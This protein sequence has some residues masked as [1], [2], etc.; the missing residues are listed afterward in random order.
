MRRGALCALG[1]LILVAFVASPSAQGVVQEQ[2]PTFRAAVDLVSVAA[3]VRDRHGRFVHD[4]Q[5][6]DFSV[7]EAGHVRPI[8]EFHA[9]DDAPVR[10]ALLF[11]V[12]G[13]MQVASKIEAARQAARQVLSS[14]RLAGRA[15]HDEAA[16]FSFDTRLQSLQGFTTDPTAIEDALARVAPFGETSL[17]D[18][19]AQT[20][21]RV[22]ASA[23]AGAQRRAVIVLT[24]GVDTSSRLTPAQVSGIA[25]E[26]DVPVYVMAVVSP[27]DHPGDPESVVP[28][29]GDDPGALQ[30]LAYWTGGE[31][32]MT[33]A[34]AHA[35]LAARQI[36]DELRHQYVFAFDATPGS[37]WRRLEV[38]TKD[39]NLT[40]RA[41]SGYIAGS[42][43]APLQP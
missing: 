27:L 32:F 8:V 15:S 9:D 25:S 22:A 4:L 34:P 24:D 26:I 6:K 33:S 17:Y 18:A 40:V 20:A 36:I 14:L 37:G 29:R 10:I 23:D 7:L 5:Q 39:R 41:R 28:A 3:V 16:V 43:G 35:S 11:D 13:S 2:R 31:L 30:N 38:R 12:S 19:V 21:R 1:W 42:T